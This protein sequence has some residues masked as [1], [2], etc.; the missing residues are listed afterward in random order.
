MATRALLGR[1][2]KRARLAG[3]VVDADLRDRL[4]AYFELL[5]RW[6]EKINLTSLLDLDEAIDRLL[7]EPVAALCQVPAQATSLIDIGSGSGSPAIPMKLARPSLHL[8]MVESKTRKA[9]FL[10]EA[11]RQLGL[12]DT[13]VEAAR[14]EVLLARPDLHEAMDVASIRA[15]RLEA[16]LLVG[17]Q[18][19][20]KPGGLLLLFRG[21][22]GSGVPALPPPLKWVGTYPLIHALGSR[23]AVVEKS[24]VGGLAPSLAS[25]S[26]RRESLRES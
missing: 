14:Y 19:F 20:L 23:L 21:P 1:I 12:S 22:G 2:E 5:R 15:V 7:L 18:A 4:L 16:R 13:V 11:V 8:V 9:A 24:P 10:R 6:N 25:A 26:N 17:V 3:L